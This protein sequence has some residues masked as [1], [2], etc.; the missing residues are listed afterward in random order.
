ML[1]EGRSCCL[2]RP[3]QKFHISSYLLYRKVWGSRSHRRFFLSVF[4]A[5]GR[6]LLL[7]REFGPELWGDQLTAYSHPRRTWCK[8]MGLSGQC[9]SWEVLIYWRHC[10]SVSHLQWKMEAP[11]SVCI[12]IPMGKKLRFPCRVQVVCGTAEL[13]AM[14]FHLPSSP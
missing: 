9:I 2:V 1:P 14:P 12:I 6:Y 4:Q 10:A 5:M 8:P 11:A 7:S 3:M 13:L